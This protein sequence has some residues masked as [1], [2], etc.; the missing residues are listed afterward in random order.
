MR[1][2]IGLER[3]SEAINKF[4]IFRYPIS[5]IYFNFNMTFL[6][7]FRKCA[8]FY[9]WE[10]IYIRK[11]ECMLKNISDRK[12]IHRVFIYVIVTPKFLYSE[13]S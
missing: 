3:Y 10:L 2:M 7:S 6:M 13:Q 9:N 1:N 8:K 11:N 12:V 5:I 4:G